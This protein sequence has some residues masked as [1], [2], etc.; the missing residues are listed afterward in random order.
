MNGSDS[1]TRLA[2]DN[3]RAQANSAVVSVRTP[4]VLPTGIPCLVA[5]FTFTLL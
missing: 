1:T 4:G 3:V 2:A 5:S